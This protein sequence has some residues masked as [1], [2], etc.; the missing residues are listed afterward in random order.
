MI[1]VV[2][3]GK[4]ATM[5]MM[6]RYSLLTSTTIPS[7]KSTACNYAIELFGTLSTVCMH[8]K[9]FLAAMKPSCGL[10]KRTTIHSTSTLCVSLLNILG[11]AILKDPIGGNPLGTRWARIL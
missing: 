8:Q 1:E 7:L 9:D 11:N 5:W 4:Q 6:G 3:V 10:P 2:F